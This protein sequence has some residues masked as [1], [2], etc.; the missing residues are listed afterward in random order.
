MNATSAE[1][2]KFLSLG[3][4][5]H[6]LKQT[7]RWYKRKGKSLSLP[8]MKELE[9][10][11]QACD[12]AILSQDR[13]TASNLALKLEEFSST[14]FKK[15]PLDYTKEILIALV[16]ALAI[17]TLVR[18]VWFELY[19]IP[20]GSMRPT[21]KEQDH[22]TVTKTAFGI[23][24]PLQTNHIYFDPDLVQRTG[25]V[26]W[27]GDD[28]PLN[29]TDSTY[30][31]IFPYK[32]RY[33][34]RLLGKPGDTLYF[35]GGK[36][37]GI[38]SHGNWIKELLDS[39]WLE[40]LEYIPI[41]TFDGQ[42]SSPG[43]NVVQFEQMHQAIGRLT[44]TRGEIIGEVFNGHDWVRDQPAAQRTPHEKIVT[45]SD[46]WGM[47][48]F[49][50]AR[51]LTKDELAQYNN[52]NKNGLED[53]ILYLQL[54]HT[55]SL[56]YP[57][58]FTQHEYAPYGIALNPYTTVI[59]LQQKH[60]DAIMENMYTCRFIVK[61]GLGKR[62][63]VDNKDFSLSSPHFPKIPNGTY[64]F[65]YGKADSIGWGGTTS[66]LPA[67]H[68]LYSHSPE[69][70]QT[71]FNMGIDM[72][73]IYSPQPFNYVLFPHRYAYFRDGDLYLLGGPV[74]KKDDPVLKKFIEREAKLESQSTPSHPYV[75][76]KDNGPPMKEGK[77]DTSFIHAFGLTIPPKVYLVL[78]DNHA[79]SADS[80]VFGFVPEDNLQGAPS[81]IIWPPGSRWG[82]PAQ[83]P[84]PLFVLPRLA[85]WGFVLLCF[86]VWYA[87]RQWDMRQPVFKRKV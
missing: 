67:N 31:W 42:L 62:Y 27:S 46:F 9:T 57:K 17:A 3:K 63:S 71:L 51:L 73:T 75:A 5:H 12:A 78:G 26:I 44:N 1:K 13:E 66:A 24:F 6:I 85:V 38:D 4:A 20:T 49:A 55:P 28:I 33:I 21:F 72:S 45:Y 87:Y 8:L 39:P 77:I 16:L 84:Y 19:E 61:D 30:F 7:Y 52:I 18:Q 41:M 36:I 76:F 83:K 35:Y 81:L 40:K 54:I 70:V 23:N 47:K 58:P 86:L 10:D 22:L 79:M 11:M 65:Y 48:N 80:R 50:M 14:H 68:P 32:K 37:Y 34:K 53:G 15:T 25:V 64:E 56:T 74:L 2:K 29:D 69:N 43:R 60:L 82:I 59:P